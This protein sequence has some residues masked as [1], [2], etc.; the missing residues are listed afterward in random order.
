[1]ALSPKLSER[2]VRERAAALPLWSVRDG[3]LH[4][5]LKFRDFVHAFGFMSSV[6]ILAEKRNHHP[7]WSNGYDRVTIDLVSHD[8]GGLSQRDFDLAAAIDALAG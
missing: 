3:K 2:E 1:M 5:E 8:V 6:A 7:D 4:R